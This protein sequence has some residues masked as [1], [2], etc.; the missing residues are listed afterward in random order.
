VPVGAPAGQLG[1]GEHDMPAVHCVGGVIG[2]VEPVGATV[3]PGSTVPLAFGIAV[4]LVP[5]GVRL[6]FGIATPPGVD[7]VG[8]VLAFGMVACASAPVSVIAAIAPA[9]N[10][11]FMLFSLN[12]SFTQRAGE[13]QCSGN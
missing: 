1:D 7:D 6:A 4:P 13:D 3:P 10:S 2:L 5:S 12:L 9:R 11:F 8:V